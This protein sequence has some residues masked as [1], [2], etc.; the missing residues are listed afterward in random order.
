MVKEG[1]YCILSPGETGVKGG[2]H[3]LGG[4]VSGW[5]RDRGNPVKEGPYG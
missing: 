1:G 3:R 4:A 2:S 5:G